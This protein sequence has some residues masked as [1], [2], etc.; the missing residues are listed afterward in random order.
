MPCTWWRHQIETFSALLAIC[1][2]NSPVT[3]EFLSQRPVTRSFDVFF[4]LRLN[5]RLSKHS[6]GWWF[7]TPSHSLWRHGNDLTVLACLS[8]LSEYVWHFTLYTWDWSCPLPF[9]LQV[10]KIWLFFGMMIKTKITEQELWHR[11]NCPA[12]TQR[13]KHV[14]IASKRRFDVIITCLLRFVFAGWHIMN[15]FLWNHY[16]GYPFY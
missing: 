14:L 1:T 12:N 11:D 3:G 10:I 15:T 2:G 16:L 13:I 8:S 9:W 7:E 5:K 6:W 4:D